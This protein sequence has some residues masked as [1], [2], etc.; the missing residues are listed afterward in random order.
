MFYKFIYPI[1][2][3][4]LSVNFSLIAMNENNSNVSQKFLIHDYKLEEGAAAYDG[5]LADLPKDCSPELI[6]TTKNGTIPENC[7]FLDRAIDDIVIQNK[8]DTKDHFT[9]SQHYE[10]TE[11]FTPTD[12]FFVKEFNSQINLNT[13][14]DRITNEHNI[15]ITNK[16]KK[17]STLELYRSAKRLTNRSKKLPEKL[18]VKNETYYLEFS[19]KNKI[20]TYYPR[21]RK[22]HVTIG[23][24]TWKPGHP[25]QTLIMHMTFGYN[26]KT[27]PTVL[28]K[29]DGLK[30]KNGATAKHTKKAYLLFSS[31]LKE[32]YDL[33]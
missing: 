31:F 11:G 4:L 10:I 7:I 25:L 26:S 27:A 19:Y 8:Q 12:N 15:T 29:A 2:C 28:Y 18:T 1:I 22:Y 16:A 23:D 30:V 20:P 9:F 13:N 3:L 21:H 33:I 5:L 6:I 32:V 17:K 24:N 14:K